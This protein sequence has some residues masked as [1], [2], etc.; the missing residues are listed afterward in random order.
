MVRHLDELLN[1]AKLG[2]ITPDRDVIEKKARDIK[3]DKVYSNSIMT[4]FGRVNDYIRNVFS[5][6]VEEIFISGKKEQLENYIVRAGIVL[7]TYCEDLNEI[8]KEERYMGEL[9]LAGFYQFVANKLGI[10][11]TLAKEF[12]A[13]APIEY[14]MEI[15]QKYMRYMMSIY[16]N[17]CKYQ[18]D[19]LKQFREEPGSFFDID[20]KKIGITLSA[21]PKSIKKKHEKGTEKIEKPKLLLNNKEFTPLQMERF[22]ENSFLREHPNKIPYPE[23]KT[24]EDYLDLL[25]N[26][27]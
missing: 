1:R 20:Q 14:Q 8:N 9:F 27:V 25:K 2:L 23:M 16:S 13:N 6:M 24:M 26:N 19:M 5:A 3:L 10:P 18:Y 7:N 21:A 11:E 12:V 4:R 15:T 17:S 22:P